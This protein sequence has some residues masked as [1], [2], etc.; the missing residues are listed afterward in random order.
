MVLH[1][2]RAGINID[3]VVSF[4]GSLGTAWPAQSGAVKA[5]ILVNNGA[6]DPFVKQEEI[7]K[8]K[9]E[10]KKAGADFQ[11][12]S[13]PGAKHSFTNPGADFFGKKFNLPL[14]YNAQADQKS[15]QAMQQFFNKIFTSN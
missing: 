14:E 2:A 3:G 5:K 11:F 6:D 1:M 15:W 8:F 4:H 9:Q 7:E 13:Y 10:M 12:N